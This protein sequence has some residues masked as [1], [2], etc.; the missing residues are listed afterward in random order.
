MVYKSVE[1]KT[2]YVGAVTDVATNS[3]A[4]SAGWRMFSREFVVKYHENVRKEKQ[5]SEKHNL[6]V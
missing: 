1:S 4:S 5:N 6:D 2:R 3:R